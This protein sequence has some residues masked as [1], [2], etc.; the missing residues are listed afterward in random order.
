MLVKISRIVSKMLFVQIKWIKKSAR[1]TNTEMLKWFNEKYV[2][3][4]LCNTDKL[5]ISNVMLET[6]PC[7]QKFRLSYS[8]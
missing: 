6:M 7:G 2:M 1:M 4:Q 8:Q 3:K 5:N